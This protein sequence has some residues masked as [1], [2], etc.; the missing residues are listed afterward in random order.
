MSTATL[1]APVKTAN[2]ITAGQVE[3][4]EE[5][6]SD[7]KQTRKPAP[8]VYY[9][10]VFDNV[11]N[12]KNSPPSY[13]SDKFAEDGTPI[14]KKG[15]LGIG[16]KVYVIKPVK[17]SKESTVET[18]WKYVWARN[19]DQALAFFSSNY[20]AAEPLE[21]GKRGKS[22]SIDPIYCA[23]MDK[24]IKDQDNDAIKVFLTELPQYRGYAVEHGYKGE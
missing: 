21:A 11:D 17:D 23:Y 18:E 4:L 15:D 16:Y 5:V 14:T 3:E 8:D 9:K 20:F 22:A 19:A 12:A 10:A 13:S 2:G 7:E 1:S 6:D 24:M